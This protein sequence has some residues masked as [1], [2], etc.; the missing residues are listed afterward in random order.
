MQPYPDWLDGLAW[1]SLSLAF[2]CALT[3]VIDYTWHRQKMWIMY[4]V[5]P[6]T[7]LYFGPLALA[8]YYKAR[9]P[10]AGQSDKEPTPLQITAGVYHCGAGCTLGDIAGSWV[11]FLL[12]WTF[13]GAAFQTE[14]V[15]DFIFAF[16]L[17][18]FFQYFTIAPMRGLGFGKRIIAALRAD[19]LSLI[20]FEIGLFAWMALSRFAIYRAE[21]HPT[22]PVHWFMM[23][24]GMI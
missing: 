11:V 9:Q 13:A 22:S 21:I 17:G 23:Q 1:A 5:W 8:V 18:I 16:V 4:V 10:K 14:L 24:I 12:G 2:L 3:I 20:A 7:A 15:I 6:V 19:T